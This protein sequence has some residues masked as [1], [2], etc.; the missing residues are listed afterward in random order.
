M[1]VPM[2]N[3]FEKYWDIANKLLEIATIL[4]PRY[5]M[6]SIEYYYRLLYDPF[7]AELRVNSTRKLFS[8]LFGEYAS[9]ASQT[10]LDAN[11]SMN[12][13]A[14][15]PSSTQSSSSLFATRL[16]LEKFIF[17]SNSSRSSK[18]E[19]EVYFED[20][21]SPGSASF[22]I[23]AWW[24]I[25]GPKYPVISR[26]A[27]DVLSVPITTAASESTFSSAKRILDDYRCNLLPET[28]E[29]I[30]CSHD[31]LK[32]RIPV[33]PRPIK[34]DLLISESFVPATRS[35]EVLAVD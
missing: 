30:M 24:K 10:P 34:D 12:F 33:D 5:K 1:V 20:P 28:I 6:K 35:E 13:E 9:Q 15:V 3:K 31:W 22:D 19:L 7:V 18:L 17:E 32:G 16:G 25:N 27:R 8:D 2:L 26:I 4:D 23:L 11:P 14:E 29:V 21:M